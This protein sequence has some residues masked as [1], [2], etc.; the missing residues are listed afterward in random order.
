MSLNCTDLI[1]IVN[2]GGEL[3]ID[4]KQYSA[5]DLIK[6]ANAISEKN[7][8]TLKNSEYFS[9]NDL[10]RIANAGKGNIIFEIS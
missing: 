10:I 8:I 4:S 7:H 2:A 6:I 5:N 1:R 3:I 9:T